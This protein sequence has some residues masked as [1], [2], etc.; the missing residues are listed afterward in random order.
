MALPKNAFHRWIIDSA[1]DFA[2]IVTD[3]S[4]KATA[5]NE[6]ARLIL[7]WSEEEMVGQTVERMF[8]P[9]DIAIDRPQTEMRE[10]LTDGLGN[11][12]RWHLR[13][14]GGRIWANGQMTCFVTMRARPSAS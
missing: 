4:G 3:L 7:G 9:E 6:G 12:E 2:V 11:D 5:W 13:R 8:T 10:A 1:T 14:D